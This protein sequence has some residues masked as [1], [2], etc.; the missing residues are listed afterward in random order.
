MVGS[1]PTI[2]DSFRKRSRWSVGITKSLIET[3]KSNIEDELHHQQLS[4]VAKDVGDLRREEEA[5]LEKSSRR[6]L[7]GHSMHSNQ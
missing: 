4:Y 3:F 1:H 5:I 6:N 7:G 2:P